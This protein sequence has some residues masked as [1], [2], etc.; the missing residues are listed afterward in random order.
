MAQLVCTPANLNVYSMSD[1]LRDVHHAHAH[2][3]HIPNMTSLGVACDVN[4]IGMMSLT[5]QFA[6][7]SHNIQLIW[8]DVIGVHIA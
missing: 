5:L 4:H 1:L 2:K 6:F 3:L 7:H 8:H